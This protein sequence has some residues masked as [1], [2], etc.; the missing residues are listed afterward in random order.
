MEA[1]VSYN[2]DYDEIKH[3]I[4]QLAAQDD[5]N[6]TMQNAFSSYGKQALSSLVEEAVAELLGWVAK[7]NRVPEPTVTA[8][9]SVTKAVTGF[10][11]R[12]FGW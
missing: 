6:R 4:D 2:K 10:I 5:T 9:K 1:A 3:I 7:K 8:I 11:F 12:M